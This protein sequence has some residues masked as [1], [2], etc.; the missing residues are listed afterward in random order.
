MMTLTTWSKIQK[1]IHSWHTVVLN[2]MSQYQ[3][4]S[5]VILN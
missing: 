5:E 4:V 1:I 2:N 3:L